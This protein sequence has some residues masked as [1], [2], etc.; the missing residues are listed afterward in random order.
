VRPTR[1]VSKPD[2]GAPRLRA[3]VRRT[4]MY[5]PKC[6]AILEEDPRGWLRCSSGQLDFTI[7]V[8][9][10]LRAMCGAVT[11]NA[12]TTPDFSGHSYFCPGCGIA[13]PKA[14]P[15]CS[16]CGIS[17]GPIKFALIEIHVHGDGSGKSF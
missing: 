12:V 17:L 6:S 1:P 10:K 9:R 8:S 13:I 14:N 5:C 11:V 4:E 7:D 15:V 2:A 3:I 16:R